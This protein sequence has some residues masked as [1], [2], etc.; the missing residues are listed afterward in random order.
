MSAIKRDMCDDL[1]SK[2]VRERADWT[3]ECCGKYFPE[4]ESRQ[5]LHCSH[6]YSRRHKATRWHPDNAFAHCFHCHQ[7]LGEDPHEFSVWATLKLGSGLVSLIR[8]KALSVFRMKKHDKEDLKKHLKEQWKIMQAKRK[9][10]ETGRIEFES[11][12]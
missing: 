3:C 12:Q 8:E 5:G 2:L 4:G 6:F 7:S 9:A 10:G 11:W 1:F